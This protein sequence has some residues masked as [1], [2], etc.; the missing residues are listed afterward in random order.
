MR[1][2]IQLSKTYIRLD[3]FIDTWLLPSISKFLKAKI[4]MH[5]QILVNYSNLF[6]DLQLYAD[7]IDACNNLIVY[8]KH[9]M[10]ELIIT[11]DPNKFNKDITAKLYDIC[12]LINFGSIECP[13][14]PIFTEVFD[15]FAQNF[16]LFFNDY[17]VGILPCP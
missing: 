16:W 17:Q 6:P 3:E 13:A 14:L 12:A 4:A 5:R 9:N 2:Y 1:L 10:D 11:I 8:H 7:L 15:Y